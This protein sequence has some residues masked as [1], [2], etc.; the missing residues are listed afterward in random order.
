MSAKKR[1]IKMLIAYDGTQYSGWQKQKSSITI[2]GEIE[3]HLGRMTRE[4]ISLHGA[5]RTDAGVHTDGMCAHFLTNTTLSTDDLLRGLNSMLSGAIRILSVEETHID[6]HSRYHAKGKVYHYLLYCGKI[7]PP[8]SRL[9]SLHVTARLDINTIHSCLSILEGTHDFSSFENSGSRDK[10]CSSGRGAVRTIH[11]ARLV[12]TSPD[13]F[14]FQFTGDGF[15]RNMIRNLVG[16]LLEG[17][18]GKLNSKEFEAILKAKN[19]TLA[20]PKAP[21][22]GLCLK[23]VLY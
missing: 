15:L 16:T 14:A 19:R 11:R 9:Y 20:G 2:Q 7:Q 1:N 8:Q 4:K 23:K 3:R 13:T 12:T 22:H 5:G 10:T 21:A 6:F 18:R 17:G